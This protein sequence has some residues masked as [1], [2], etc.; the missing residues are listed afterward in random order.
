MASVSIRGARKTYAGNPAEV[1]KG[2]DLD[3]AD[4]EFLVMLGPSGCGKS[5]C[6]GWS[7]GWNPLQRAKSPS[8]GGW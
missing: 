5:T 3:V 8:A 4:G 6:S 7:P 1:I 2:I